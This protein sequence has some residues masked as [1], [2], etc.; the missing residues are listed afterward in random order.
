MK[1]SDQL[2]EIADALDARK[3][4]MKVRIFRAPS[5]KLFATSDQHPKA[6]YWSHTDDRFWENLGKTMRE[7]Y[8]G[9]ETPSDPAAP[10]PEIE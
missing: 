3:P 4:D 8:R 1:T 9:V 10:V 7:W 6:N 2:R 5:G